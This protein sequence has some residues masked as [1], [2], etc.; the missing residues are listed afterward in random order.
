MMQSLQK[1]KPKQLTILLTQTFR[2]SQVCALYSSEPLILSIHKRFVHGAVHC[3]G[4]SVASRHVS[5]NFIIFVLLSSNL[6]GITFARTLHYQFYCWYF[7]ALPFLLFQTQLPA[8][9]SLV[10]IASVE[11]C[12]NVYPATAWSSALLQLCH[13][14]LLAALYFSPVPAREGQL[15]RKR[16]LLS[17]E[18][19][20]KS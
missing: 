2:Q 12:F 8:A 10:I 1:R 18:N 19:S 5:S 7:H 3:A 17:I 9:A 16:Q 13:I 20:K 11:V 4:D 14:A 15:A 6:V